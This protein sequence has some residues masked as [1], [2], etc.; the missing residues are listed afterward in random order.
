LV[1]QRDQIMDD[2]NRGIEAV[3]AAMVA[4]GLRILGT[5]P[6]AGVVEPATEYTHIKWDR[7]D[8][9]WALFAVRANGDCLLVRAP[10]NVRLRAVAALPALLEDMEVKAAEDV[11]VALA[12]LATTTAFVDALRAAAGGATEVRHDESASKG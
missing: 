11:R 5:A 6:L 1:V 12:A 7:A 9:A 10:V 2:L 8:A 3:A 4:S